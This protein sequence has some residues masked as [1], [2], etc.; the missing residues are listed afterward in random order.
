LFKAFVVQVAHRGEHQAMRLLQRGPGFVG[1]AQRGQRAAV[2]PPD[3]LAL[4]ESGAGK[5]ALA[6]QR[7]AAPRGAKGRDGL[8]LQQQRLGQRNQCVELEAGVGGLHLA[9]EGAQPSR[10]CAGIAFGQQQRADPQFA[11][12]ARERLVERVDQRVVGPPARAHPCQV[13][14]R[15]LPGEHG[16]HLEC[17]VQARAH[18]PGQVHALFAQPAGMA[19]QPQLAEREREVADDEHAAVD[20]AGTLESLCRL[21]QQRQAFGNVRAAEAQHVQRIGQAQVIAGPAR[22]LDRAL[23]RRARGLVQRQAGLRE[24]DDPMGAAEVDLVA[25]CFEQAGGAPSRGD[26]GFRLR[27]AQLRFGH[28]QQ[29]ARQPRLAAAFLRQRHRLLGHA[30]RR[31][32]MTQ[33]HQH[34]GL[35]VQRP[36]PRPG[37]A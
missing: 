37:L 32:V 28:V 14:E 10:G 30:Q 11:V 36:D 34:Q 5:A 13:A 27:R 18:A 33:A 35:A 8:A 31:L 6:Q 1:T 25:G 2:P 19:P 21:L 9:Q 17:Q 16:A 22:E 4:A 26:R 24:G 29:A 15:D 12:V 23:R 3:V 20:V 7:G